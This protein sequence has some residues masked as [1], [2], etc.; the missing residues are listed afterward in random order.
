MA[1]SGL[2][3]FPSDPAVL[4]AV[5]SARNTVVSVHLEDSAV[6]PS[7]VLFRTKDLAGKMFAAA[8]VQ[9]EWHGCRQPECDSLRDESVVVSF[10]K[11]IRREIFPGALAVSRPIEGVHI[12]VF[13]DRV[14]SARGG[15]SQ[16]GLAQVLAHVLVHE[17][18]HIL[19][20]V[21]RHS[22][23]GIMKANW[24]PK[25]YLDMLWKPLPFTPGD[26]MLIQAGLAVRAARGNAAPG[27]AGDDTASTEITH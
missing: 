5:Q 23:T 24:S 2:V 27:I 1:Y 25:D 15:F 21:V 8:G 19:Q 4:A 3:I 12:S 7:P 20:G 17:I 10:L 13:Y 18:T 16:Q 14:Q 6:V 9:I 26:L 11:G 22:E